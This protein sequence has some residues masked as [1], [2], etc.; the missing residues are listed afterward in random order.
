MKP[1]PAMS[2]SDAA[3]RLQVNP[4]RVRAMI[5]SSLLDAEKVGH[6][7]LVDPASV[8]RRARARIRSGGPLKPEN[9]WAILLMKSGESVDWLRPWARSRDR[10][11]LSNSSIEQLAADLA[12]RA[13][14]RRFRAHSSDLPRIA[15][16][17]AIVLG[18]VSAASAHNLDVSAPGVVEAYVSNQHL[19]RLSKEYRLEPSS[20]PN[21]LLRAVK[22][23]WPFPAS[24][25][26]V[27]A[28]IA[29]ID[30]LE[31]DDP[32]SRRAG[33]QLLRSRST[34]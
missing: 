20:N 12:R 6:R 19:P 17:P 33:R 1:I 34:R 13:D 4:S 22:G 30:L 26:V 31:A 24:A 27:P 10:Q 32:R 2:V 11:R 28:I 5:Q 3:A 25:R 23:R 18:G 9:A 29:A 14:L 15:A 7:W 8:E 21:V 16:D